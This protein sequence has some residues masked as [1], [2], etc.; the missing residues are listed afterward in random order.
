M[1]GRHLKSIPV[2]IAGILCHQRCQLYKLGS[3]LAVDVHSSILLLVLLP[4]L[5]LAVHLVSEEGHHV[6]WYCVATIVVPHRIHCIP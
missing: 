1:R 5:L 2:V 3:L 6:L 4:V